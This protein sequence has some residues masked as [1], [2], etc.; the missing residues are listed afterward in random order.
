VADRTGGP[1]QK[2]HHVVSAAVAPHGAT[3][4]VRVLS[5]EATLIWSNALGQGAPYYVPTVNLWDVL[6]RAAPGSKWSDRQKAD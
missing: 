2:S 6:V 4:M 1:G 3:E 5:P